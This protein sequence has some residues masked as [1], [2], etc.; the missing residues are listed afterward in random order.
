M[1][2]KILIDYYTTELDPISVRMQVPA[3]PPE[4]IVIIEKIG[5]SARDHIKQSTIA[6]QSYADS[7]YEA[8]NLN[9]EVK[10]LAEGLTAHPDICSVE[11]NSDYNFTDTASKKYRYQA[12]FNIVH[13]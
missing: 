11:L 8:A 6:I 12:V 1:I 5:S 3:N 9:E 13:Y 7:I 2:E 4:K 10:E